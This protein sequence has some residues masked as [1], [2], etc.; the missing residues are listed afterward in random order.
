MI[1]L[2]IGSTEQ[3]GPHLALSTDT[4]IAI[5]LAERLALARGDVVVAPALAYGSSGEHSGFAGTISIGQDALEMLLVEWGRSASETFSRMIFVSAHGGNAAPVRAAGDC[6]VRESRAIHLWSPSWRGDAHAGRM[7][8]SMQL[9]LDPG[10]VRL[11]RAEPG[12]VTAME[13]LL[14]DLLRGGVRSV[15]PNGVLGDP[16][17]ASASAGEALLCELADDLAVS[18]AAWLDTLK[19]LDE[20]ESPSSSMRRGVTP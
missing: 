13:I 1:A 9:A 5:S 18:V 11:E 7:E 15:S 19:T 20:L 17:G 16:V 14:P 6:L 8:T 4:D 3:H 10:R 12:N 2:P